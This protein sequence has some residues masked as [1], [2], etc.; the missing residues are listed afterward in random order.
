MK[1]IKVQQME[2][3]KKKKEKEQKLLQHINSCIADYKRE[4]YNTKKDTRYLLEVFDDFQL[5]TRPKC[6]I[7]YQ[8]RPSAETIAI[9]NMHK[10][11]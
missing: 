2:E 11:F 8:K 10:K 4:W 5:E 6:C 3:A 7:C 1:K 9:K